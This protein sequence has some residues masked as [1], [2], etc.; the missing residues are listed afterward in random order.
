MGVN[1]AASRYNLG[2][3]AAMI[4]GISFSVAHSISKSNMMAESSQSKGK[5]PLKT[6]ASLM[7]SLIFAAILFFTLSSKQQTTVQ[8]DKSVDNFFSELFWIGVFSITAKAALSISFDDGSNSS[9]SANSK[10]RRSLRE[11]PAHCKIMCLIGLI[12]CGLVDKSLFAY[13]F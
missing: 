1:T 10:R 12:Y 6:M 8:K 2:L 4:S 11:N 9:S 13:E 5:K 7:V 3:A